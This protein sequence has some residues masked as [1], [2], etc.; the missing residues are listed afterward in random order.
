MIIVARAIEVGPRTVA[1]TVRLPSLA[2]LHSLP[3]AVPPA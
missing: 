1:F 3:S 2:A